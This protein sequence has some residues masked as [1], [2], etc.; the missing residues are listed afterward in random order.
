MWAPDNE[1]P[2]PPAARV[3]SRLGAARQRLGPRPGLRR[4][5]WLIAH[6]WMGLGLAAFLVMAGLTG[7]LLAFNAEIDRAIS[8]HMMTVQDRP[9]AVPLDPFV[10]RERL[11]ARHPEALLDTV[12]LARDPGAA[13]LYTHIEPRPDPATGRPRTIDYDELLVD[14]YTGDE[15]GRRLWGDLSQGLKNLMP[16]IYRLHYSLALGSVGSYVMGIVAL[17]WTLDCLVGAGLTLPVRASQRAGQPV[18]PARPWGA[19]WAAAWRVRWT[20]GAFKLNFDLHRAGGLWAWAM[21][22]VVAWSAVSFN[23]AGVY[24]PVMRALFGLDD[25]AAGQGSAAPFDDSA[26]AWRAAHARGRALMAEFAAREGFSVEREES[27][28]FVRERQAWRYAVVSSR[29]PGSRRGATAVWFV[30][31]T[32]ALLA[33][34]VPTGRRAGSTLTAWLTHLHTARVGGLPWRLFM[35]VLGG[36]VVMLSV[37]GVVVWRRKAS[38]RRQAAAHTLKVRLTP[39]A[40]P[41]RSAGSRQVAW[42]R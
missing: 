25:K 34:Q 35:C 20:A 29:D 6:R 3:L 16:F 22:F 15:L 27:L 21:L 26:P 42:R 32:G 33:E 11:Q 2:M 28:G 4:G 40:V 1:V 23:L 30:P 39:A 8:P 12:P 10:L 14:P 19:R 7:S 5:V 41:A 38:A 13:V 36:L 24:E 31:G 37:T 17:V 9:G 18:R